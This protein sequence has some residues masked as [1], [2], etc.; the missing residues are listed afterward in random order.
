VVV[1]FRG[2]FL[3][4]GRITRQII[5]V[6]RSRF[7]GAVHLGDHLTWIFANNLCMKSDEDSN[8]QEQWQNVAHDKVWIAEESAAASEISEQACPATFA[9]GQFGP[10]GPVALLADNFLTIWR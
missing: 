2:T 9:A 5:V 10:A 6:M 4:V 1:M 7:F 8:Q 3:I